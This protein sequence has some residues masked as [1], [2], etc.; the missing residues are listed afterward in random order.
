MLSKIKSVAEF[1]SATRS[2]IGEGPSFDAIAQAQTTNLTSMIAHNPLEVDDSA[3]VLRFLMSE[4]TGALF[5][6][7]GR[8]R[9]TSAIASSFQSPQVEAI[10]SRT[11]KVQTYLH[12]VNY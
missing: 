11:S 3:A 8:K 6:E 2:A 4:N 10:A 12:M 9:L 5:G 7:E 1:L